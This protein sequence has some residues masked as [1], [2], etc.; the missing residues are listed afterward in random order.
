MKIGRW[1]DF[2]LGS[3]PCVPLALSLS[4]SEEESPPSLSASSSSAKLTVGHLNP[5]TSAD[6]G[7]LGERVIDA[8]H[9]PVTF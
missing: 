6:V 2:G 8:V 1:P 9:F 5:Q 4:S 7:D 3:W